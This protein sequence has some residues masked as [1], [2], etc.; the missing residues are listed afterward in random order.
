MTI[1]GIPQ[2]TAYVTSLSTNLR[3]E[4]TAQVS[5]VFQ[6]ELNGIIN[7]AP[8]R[9]GA[10]RRSGHFVMGGGK[11]ILCQIVF[12]A[13]HA[14]YVNFG[15]FRMMSRPFATNGHKRIVSKLKSGK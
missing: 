5:S 7:D 11:G 6:S 14:G 15:T 10:L 4:V 1:D 8:I 2:L 12:S 9:T 3:K 13:G